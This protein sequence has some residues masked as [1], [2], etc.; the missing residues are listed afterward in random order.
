MQITIDLTRVRKFLRD[1]RSDLPKQRNELTRQTARDTLTQVIERNPV[2]TGR[3][4]SAWV[5]AL[6]DLDGTPPKNWQGPNP[7]ADAIRQGAKEGDVQESQSRHQ[8]Q[9]VITNSVPYVAHLEY[10]T[11]RMR[12][13]RMVRQALAR[14]S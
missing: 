9:I 5:A 8:T 11:R 13:F 10:G 1:Q 6:E 7:H 2:D 12:A 4:R 3:S 14:K